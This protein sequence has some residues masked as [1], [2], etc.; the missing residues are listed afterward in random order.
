MEITYVIF[1]KLIWIA[2]AVCSK[3]HLYY[4]PCQCKI[5]IEN[6]FWAYHLYLGILSAFV[7][8]NNVTWTQIASRE[9][10]ESYFSYLWRQFDAYACS[11]FIR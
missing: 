10:S 11:E 7:G 5:P 3:Q 9:H 4:L 6:L 2:Y 1:D 8:V